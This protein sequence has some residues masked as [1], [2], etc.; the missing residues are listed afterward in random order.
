MRH[1]RH[2]NQNVRSYLST[3]KNAPDLLQSPEMPQLGISEKITEKIPAR[4]N[5]WNAKKTPPKYRKIP[6]MCILVFWGYFFGIFGP[7]I[8][9]V[10]NFGSFSWRVGPSWGSVAGRGVLN[11]APAFRKHPKGTPLAAS[12][13]TNFATNVHGTEPNPTSPSFPFPPPPPLFI[14][15]IDLAIVCPSF[16]PFLGPKAAKR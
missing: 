11:S 2:D 6:K 14:W 7:K 3:L 12:T 8:L 5:F 16:L 13:N 10:Q 1:K 4:P 15:H 9:E